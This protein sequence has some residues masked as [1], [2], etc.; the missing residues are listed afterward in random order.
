MSK[1]NPNQPTPGRRDDLRQQQLAAAAA[2]KRVRVAIRTA[3]ITGLAVIALLVG[4]SVWSLV[5]ARAGNSNPQVAAG[6]LTVPAVAT[7]SGAVLIG[8][9]DAAVTVTVYADFMCPY[10]GQFER[11]NG[12]AL[13]DAVD[14]GTAKLELHP[15]AFLDDLSSGSKYSTRAA[16]AFV[17][18]AND[19][20]R[21]ALRF[22]GLLYANQPGEGSAGLT[23][24][25]IA[26][27]ATQ[28]GATPEV[29]ASFG[30]QTY[31]PWVAKITQQAWDSG[32]T[33]TPTVKINGSVFTGD[34]FTAGPLA[35]AIDAA[36]RD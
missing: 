16:N 27:L 14:R 32:V 30:R 28:A 1:K 10:C 26:E 24:T 36:A 8:R 11:A 19:D 13:A 23:D 25:R 35:A 15:M 12:N 34:L 3:W 5:G 20:P 21:V 7:D 22:S 9:A 17:T 6:G 29:T 2:A 33:G 31:Q 4:I 18:I